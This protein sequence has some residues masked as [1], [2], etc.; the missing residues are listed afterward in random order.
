MKNNALLIIALFFLSL[1]VLSQ[2][3]RGNTDYT[4]NRSGG[5]TKGAP[6]V[7]T[8]QSTPVKIIEFL[9]GTWTIEQVF[10]GKNELTENDTTSQDQMLVF[11]SE[12]RY[13][14]YSG[15]E[16]IDSGAY[17]VNEDHAILYLSSETDDKTH[18]WNVAFSEDGTMT[19][20]IRDGVTHGER[21]RYVYRRSGSAS[22]D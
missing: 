4:N 22:R 8:K 15:S 17:R 19:M 21:Y 10:R 12:G 5:Q 11:N 9:P 18:E 16:R 6:Q 1:P 3:K 20:D 7:N 2:D 14:S 13:M